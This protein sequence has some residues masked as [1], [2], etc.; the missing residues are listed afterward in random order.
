MDT[1]SDRFNAPQVLIVGATGGFGGALAQVLS[2]RG[3]GVHAL[4][5]HAAVAAGMA[6]DA[7]QADRA[8]PHSGHAPAWAAQV[9]W[10]LGDAMNAADVQRAAQG[11]QFIVH[12]ASPAGYVGWEALAL[13]ML[14][15]SLAA[16]RSVG[17][18]LVLPGN[19]Y[20]F[21]PDA[22]SVL[23]EGSPQRPLTRK[24]RLRVQME[25]MLR[26]A[27]QDTAAP[28]R[29]L[30]LRAGD[31]FGGHAPASWFTQ[32]LVKPGKPVRRVVFPGKAEVGHAWAYLPDAA[33]TMARLMV[34][35]LLEPG[36]LAA[37]ETLHLRG[38][39]LARGIEMP[40]AIQRVASAAA[41][42][43]HEKYPAARIK[44][45][46]WWPVSLAAPFVPMLREIR[47]M[48]Y[49]WHVP[50]QLDN[51][52]LQS[53]IGPEPHTPLDEAVRASLAEMGCLQ[54]SG[55]AHA[56]APRADVLADRQHIGTKPAGA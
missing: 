53:L 6:S 14:A 49:L 41:F 26:Q 4:T 32:M 25:D 23:H 43:L 12:A 55:G 35:D 19:V 9:Q 28:V 21:G 13:P 24:G 30:V 11:M 18:R 29:A 22:G 52:K 33:E 44:R 7:S 48:R 15:N 50:L 40:E 17:A 34:L 20:N 38:H 16:A 5:R 54:G 3:W 2:H 1:F 8:W 45:M 37:F 47:E 46:S 51:R 27:S 39:W 56:P 36:R 42:S 10:H 31:F